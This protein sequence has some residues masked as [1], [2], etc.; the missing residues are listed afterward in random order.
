MG[1][2]VRLMGLVIT[3]LAGLGAGAV[4]DKV[5]PDANLNVV[6]DIVQSDDKSGK[7]DYVKIVKYVAVTVLAAFIASKILSMIGLRKYKLL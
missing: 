7:I 5:A 1:I 3:L 2:A 4:V 6:K